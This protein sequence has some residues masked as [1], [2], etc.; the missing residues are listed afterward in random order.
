LAPIG[1]D[2]TFGDEVSRIREEFGSVTRVTLPAN[3]AEKNIKAF[4][5]GSSQWSLPEALFNFWISQ[6]KAGGTYIKRGPIWSKE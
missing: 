4:Y 5:H 1:R 2:D 6:K 3:M